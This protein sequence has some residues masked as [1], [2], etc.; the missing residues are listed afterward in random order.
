VEPVRN[1]NCFAIRV[2]SLMPR[3]YRVPMS[4]PDIQPA[5]IELV[6]QALRS[7]ILSIGP[8]IEELERAFAAYIGTRHAIAVA[9]GTSG[10]HL[11]IRAAEIADGDEVITTPF[12]FVASANC[13]LYERA[14]PV[15]VDIDEESFNLDPALIGAAV[16]ERTRAVLPVHIFGQPCAM[17]ELRSVCG[18]HDLVLIEDACEAVGAEYR[19]RKVGTFGKAAVFGFYANKQMTMGEGAIITT[20]DPHWASLLRSLRN[21]GRNASGRGFSHE[22][23][24]YNY[25][26]DEMSAA[27]GLAQLRRLDDLLARRAQ[28]AARYGEL[29]RGVPGISLRRMVAYTTRPSWFVYVLQLHREIDR[30]RVIA[31]LEERQ[32]PSRVYFSPIHLQPYYRKRFGFREGDFPVSER[33][34]ASTL[35]VP[36]HA[37]LSDDD[38]AYVVDSL[39]SAVVRA[40]A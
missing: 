9:N 7:G 25:R 4:A 17:D 15:F 29:L 27:L 3:K 38:M 5:D 13:L 32:I 26:L 31:Q 22:H 28:V 21:Q 40:A 35:A 36:F 16:T 34:A 33:I 23:L 37:N 20:D 8:F 19:G 12:S 1:K 10:L 11:C 18:A 14:V 30:N 24:G 39:R 2:L 6:T